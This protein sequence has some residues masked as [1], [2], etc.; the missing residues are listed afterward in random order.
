MRIYKE[1]DSAELIQNK[2]IID[3]VLE[4]DRDRYS[5]LVKRY[6]ES[7][8]ALAYSYLRDVQAAEDVT[9][10][11]FIKAYKTLQTLVSPQAFGAWVAQITRNLC[12][13]VLRKKKL[14]VRP[15]DN[16]HYQQEV[17]SADESIG[18]G[19]KQVR[20]LL[21]EAL[22]KLSPKICETIT[23]FYFKEQSIKEIAQFLAISEN[24]VKQRLHRGRM[25]LREH[26]EKALSEGLREVKLSDNFYSGV[27]MALPTKPIEIGVLSKGLLKAASW[28]MSVF[29]FT[30]IIITLL[31]FMITDR[32]M[33]ADI[34]PTYRPANKKTM[35]ES[36]LFILL[37]V[38]LV[39]IYSELITKY[40]LLSLGF[41]L[42][43]F[44]SLL[45]LRQ[46]ILLLCPT[47]R[48]RIGAISL[49]A[50]SVLLYL[51]FLY[52]YRSGD[53]FLWI[54]AFFLTM[55]WGFAPAFNALMPVTRKKNILSNDVVLE[56]KP[57][58][59]DFLKENAMKFAMMVNTPLPVI[60]EVEVQEESIHFSNQMPW[61]LS[62]TRFI[63]TSGTFD[64][65]LYPNGN[66]VA[67]TRDPSRLPATMGTPED[68]HQRI[69]KFIGKKWAYYLAGNKKAARSV[70]LEIFPRD[71]YIANKGHRIV[72][73]LICLCIVF[74]VV[75][76]ARQLHHRN[77]TIT[78]SDLR[79]F[80][81]D[82][83]L[84]HYQND[85]QKIPVD[86]LR[87]ITY[88]KQPRS[89]M[90]IP[91]VKE[92]Y[93]KLL[94]EKIPQEL[95]LAIAFHSDELLNGLE[96]GYLTGLLLSEWGFT[97]EA[98]AGL[99]GSKREWASLSPKI[100]DNADYLEL[101]ELERVTAQVRLFHLLGMLDQLDSRLPDEI[102]KRVWYGGGAFRISKDE[103]WNEL[104]TT[105]HM[106]CILNL[107]DR[108]DLVDYE[109]VKTWIVNWPKQNRHS[110]SAEN[111]YHL[112]LGVIS[113]GA[114][115]QLPLSDLAVRIRPSNRV[116]SKGSIWSID[117][118]DIN[119]YAVKEILSN[120]SS[121][122]PLV[123]LHVGRRK[124]VQ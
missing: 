10:E 124:I 61:L 40:P 101:S 22:D 105:C 3:A 112:A 121:I 79:D 14:N 26:L 29:W 42:V 23:L 54:N 6:S 69:K 38:V 66:I 87:M 91:D 52:P 1:E 72:Q 89:M 12:K 31:T 73:C 4:G 77:P 114:M 65:Y 120:Y 15:L 45:L 56:A 13:A 106:A 44:M 37:L 48:I 90:S 43:P 30:T 71:Y 96:A 2:E 41:L 76:L 81:Q 28:S 117:P 50:I 100:M 119:E 16:T 123:D 59:M 64:A 62:W 60:T 110:S 25:L 57:K 102:I 84:T 33:T 103:Y 92:A 36:F 47:W 9:Q 39:S 63:T 32:L 11:S 24:T 118:Y 95:Y 82:E 94:K 49:M 113:V 116:A 21:Q 67:K 80:Y 75:G 68:Y 70:T 88:Y 111:M 108:W 55:F 8:H 115:D 53:F 109:A 34:S 104:E 46:K 83:F 85:F 27:M 35:R 93:T 7:T 99:E 98:V 97:R 19:E 86:K 122:E 17:R 20:D 78:A 51:E 74:M 18:V 107:F 5:E 58:T